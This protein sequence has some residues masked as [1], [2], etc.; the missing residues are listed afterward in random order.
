MSIE[1][2][3]HLAAVLAA[4]VAFGSKEPAHTSVTLVLQM[5]I[6]HISATAYTFSFNCLTPQLLT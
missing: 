1:E 4:A 3:A 2:K 5:I 6:R